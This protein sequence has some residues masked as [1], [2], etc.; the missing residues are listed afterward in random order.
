MVRQS[1]SDN[2]IRRDFPNLPCNFVSDDN[3]VSPQII[4]EMS[5]LPGRINQRC[6]EKCG[7]FKNARYLGAA[8]SMDWF[9]P[10]KTDL[11]YEKK[12]RI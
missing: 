9:W 1:E 7:G 4:F 5:F 2:F 11:L 10:R 8:S 6:S 12:Q 3:Q